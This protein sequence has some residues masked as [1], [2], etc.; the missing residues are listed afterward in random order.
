MKMFVHE[1]YIIVSISLLK[2][3]HLIII[4]WHFLL[5]YWYFSYQYILVLSFS[6]W[7]IYFYKSSAGVSDFLTKKQ[8]YYSFI[9]SKILGYIFN[10]LFDKALKFNGKKVCHTKC[11][12]LLAFLTTYFDGN[13]FWKDIFQWWI[14]WMICTSIK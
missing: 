8:L 11:V 5:I 12:T 3:L 2:T 7:P 1:T 13:F 10:I 9:I 4:T 14:T 6:M